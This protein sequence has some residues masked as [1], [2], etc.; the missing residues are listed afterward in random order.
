VAS[1][2]LFAAIRKENFRDK[3]KSASLMHL[4]TISMCEVFHSHS[5]NQQK[6]IKVVYNGAKPIQANTPSFANSSGGGRGAIGIGG[7]S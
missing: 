2:N 7:S 5:G 1:K 6:T 4:A 3:A